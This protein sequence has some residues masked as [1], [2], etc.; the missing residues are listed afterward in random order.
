MKLQP[1]LLFCA[2][3]A[4]VLLSAPQALA[5]SD[6]AEAAQLDGPKYTCMGAERSR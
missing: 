4:A 1:V 6:A 2:S 5:K 3:A